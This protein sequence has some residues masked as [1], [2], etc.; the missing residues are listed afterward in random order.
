MADMEWREHRPGEWWHVFDDAPKAMDTPKEGVL[1]PP[2]WFVSFTAG[3]DGRPLGTA[4]L[5]L[6][7][8][9]NGDS[10]SDRPEP[11]DADYLHVCGAD[12][13]DDLIASLT[14]LRRRLYP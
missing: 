9:Y 5:H 12:G 4:C 1:Y 13:L 3:D 2:D 11:P 8:L 14:E 7:H 6:Y 10:P